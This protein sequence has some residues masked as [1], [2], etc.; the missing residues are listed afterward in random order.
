MITDHI[1]S[2]INNHGLVSDN[3]LHVVGVVSNPVRYHSRYRLFRDWVER[4]RSTPNVQLHLVELAYGDRH[5]ECTTSNDLQLRTN[6]EL[7]YKEAMINQGVK[8]LLPRDWKYVCWCDTDITFHNE[9]W[10][11]ETLHQLQAYDLIQPWS[12][13]VDMGVDGNGMQM[14]RSFSSL[15]QKNIQQQAHK[16]EPYPYG[17]SGFAWACTR[18]FWEN[19]HGLMEFPILGSGDHHMAWASIGQVEKS[20]HQKMS[21]S[22]KNL[23]FDWQR[24][25]MRITH[26]H[27]GHIKGLITHHWHGSKKKRFY[28]ER[29]QILVEH[30][31]DPIQ[32]LRYDHQG[33]PYIYGKPHLEEEIRGYF[34][35]RNEDGIDE[36]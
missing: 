19:V 16:D 7:W 18:I 4:M 21:Y 6:H 30:K 12:E 27:L 14:F 24:N 31:F 8:S 13:C 28:R 9:H 5:F 32:D 25:A 11:Q 35:S 34:R 17:H 22:F 29:W 1:V 10:A 26:G 2:S 23:C 15:V 20:V 3:T 36:D 33:L